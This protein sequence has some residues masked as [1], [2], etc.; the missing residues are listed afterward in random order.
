ML[1]GLVLNLVYKSVKM[2]RVLLLNIHYIMRLELLMAMKF[3]SYSNVVSY[4]ITAW[5]HIP[6]DCHSEFTAFTR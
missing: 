1:H 2:V 5:Y 6:E 4:H 3:M